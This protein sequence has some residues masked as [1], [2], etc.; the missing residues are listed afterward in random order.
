MEDVLSAV[1]E[2]DYKSDHL[3]RLVS[4]NKKTPLQEL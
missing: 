2:L 4:G 3:Y 1:Y